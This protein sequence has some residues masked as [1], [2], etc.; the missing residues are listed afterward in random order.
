MKTSAVFISLLASAAIVLS[1]A[2]PDGAR[3]AR[4]GEAQAV[5]IR[6]SG[7]TRVWL[8][9]V[10]E[11]VLRSWGL[12]L[13]KANAET[14]RAKQAMQS[15]E[16]RRA[17]ETAKAAELEKRTKYLLGRILRIR[18]DGLFVRCDD[19]VRVRTGGLSAV[20]GGGPVYA[21][22]T[23]EVSGEVLLIGHPKQNQLVNDDWV[24]CFAVE[25]GIA[26]ISNSLSVRRWKFVREKKN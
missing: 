11:A 16:Q 6:P 15:A 10:P 20:G 19:Q 8:N 2:T 5:V 4:S 7:V 26:R 21:P 1:Q 13:E 18:E 25:D 9:Q 22:P 14:T 3:W 23:S 12:T 24:N 17:E